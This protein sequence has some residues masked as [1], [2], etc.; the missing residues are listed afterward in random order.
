MLFII[1]KRFLSILSFTLNL[2]RKK[3]RER[4]KKKYLFANFYSLLLF[5]VPGRQDRGELKGLNFIQFEV[6]PES[7]DK[8]LQLKIEK[9]RENQMTRSF[10]EIK[11]LKIEKKINV[12]FIINKVHKLLNYMDLDYKIPV[13]RLD[14]YFYQLFNI[15][16]FA[17][18]F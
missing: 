11:F 18:I 7:F 12:S 17:Y 8:I 13:R 16:N 4:K 14:E 10:K 5:I 1:D 9:G 3:R 6:A 2:N 15:L